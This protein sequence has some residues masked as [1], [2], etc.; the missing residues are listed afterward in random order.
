MNDKD[1]DF[2]TF[3]QI[4]DDFIGEVGTLKRTL[5]ERELKKDL[6]A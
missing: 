4:K 2:F 3:D 1:L 6:V 5:Y